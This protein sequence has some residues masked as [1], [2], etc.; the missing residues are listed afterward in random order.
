M[1]HQASHVQQN[2]HKRNQEKFM[3]KN[4]LW[5]VCTKFIYTHLFRKVVETEYISG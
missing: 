4:E 1:R 2:V 3:L 5:Y